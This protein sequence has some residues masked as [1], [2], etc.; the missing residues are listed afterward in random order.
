MSLLSYIARRL[1][2]I[3]PILLG[4]TFIT[5][6]ISRVTVPDPARTWAGPRA[7]AAA[8]AALTIRFHLKDPL[9]VQYFY[10]IRDL[11][12]GNWGVSPT[13]GRPVL[14]DL[15]IYFPATAELAIAAIIITILIGIPLGVIAALYQNK[16]IDHSIRVIY[17]A[18]FSSPPFFVA[19]LFLFV[20]SYYFN[21]FPTNGEL[22]SSLI[23]PARHTGMFIVD[24]LITGN[25]VD[26]R[27]SL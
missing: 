20:F 2:L 3:I 24:S 18:G 27:D 13:S 21:V 10:Y 7:S 15:Q 23:P 6:V 12:S 25:W 8:I 9:Y 1:L 16:K 22:S 17:L 4:T 11:A 26:L 14:Y 5:F 19:L